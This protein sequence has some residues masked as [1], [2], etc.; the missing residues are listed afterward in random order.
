MENIKVM[1]R[2]R[3]AETADKERQSDYLKAYRLVLYLISN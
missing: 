3:L 1:A 2:Q